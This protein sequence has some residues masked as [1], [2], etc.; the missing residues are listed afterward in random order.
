MQDRFTRT[1]RDQSRQPRHGHR[2]VPAAGKAASVGLFRG[3]QHFFREVRVEF[4]RVHWPTRD[5]T[6]T[7][8]GVVVFVALVLAVF[9]GLIDLGLSRAL[10]LIIG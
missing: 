3:I 6:V 5:A 4:G 2:L 1:D 7:S 10:K 9:L 8:T